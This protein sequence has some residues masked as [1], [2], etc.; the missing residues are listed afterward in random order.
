MLRWWRGPSVVQIVLRRRLCALS[1]Y[2]A[3]GTRKHRPA[4]TRFWRGRMDGA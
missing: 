4:L 1:I 3:S 2:R